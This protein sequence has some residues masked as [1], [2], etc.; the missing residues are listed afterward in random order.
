MNEL[1]DRLKQPLL[2]RIIS[3]LPED[4]P[5]YLV[6]GAIRDA[7]LNRD[8]Y[9][10]DFVTPGDAIEI[11][12]RI[13]DKIGAAYFPLDTERNMARLV[14]KP[15]AAQNYHAGHPI[16]IDFS[17]YQGADLASDLSARDFTIN[18][19]AVEVHELQTMVDPQ[20]GAQDLL[21]KRLRTC[22]E[23]SFIND[24]VRILRAVRFSISLE[25][26]ISS[27]T[28][29]QMR[30]AVNHLPIVSAERM[31]DELFRILVQP[32]PSTA[33]RLLDKLDALEHILPE[34]CMLKGVEQ[35]YPHVLDAWEHTLD[36]L[37]RLESVLGVL[38]D[39]FN[40]DKASNLTLGLVSVQLGR[41][42]P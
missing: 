13:G 36:S 5:V 3:L 27:E 31:R 42:R 32:H 24:P 40:P 12:R 35:S 39:E 4:V 18:A 2:L 37:S 7:L 22:S 23:R 9:D 14:L 15:E 16:R 28:L 21:A 17:T 30:Q 29:Q 33:L 25:L 11:A 10:L 26:H 19:M 1:L 20:G 38:A 6:G 41:Y 8:S 34:I